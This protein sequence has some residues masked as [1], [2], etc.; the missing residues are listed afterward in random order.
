M[1]YIELFSLLTTW[2]AI[3]QIAARDNR[4]KGVQAAC[5]VVGKVLNL[6]QV[7]IKQQ[8]VL[9]IL[10]TVISSFYSLSVFAKSLKS[11]VILDAAMTGCVK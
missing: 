5:E 4:I 10:E 9:E 8:Q 7:I 3:F 2:L 6:Y 11:L 1:T